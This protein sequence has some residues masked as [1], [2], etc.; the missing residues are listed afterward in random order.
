[1]AVDEY[2]TQ[3][4]SPFIKAGGAPEG[5]GAR[6]TPSADQPKVADVARELDRAHPG[7]RAIE[8][9]GG[10][11]FE[12]GLALARGPPAIDH[13]VA[14]GVF[15]DKGRDEF[16]RVL[17]VGIEDDEGIANRVR[18]PAV[19]AISLPKFRVR[20]TIVSAGWVRRDPP[21]PAKCRRSCHH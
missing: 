15:L 20:F 12:P 4:K 2:P 17:E 9:A 11:G 1:M 18:N 14:L 6:R 7:H 3:A 19:S 8:Q 10:E 13:V 21:S 16:G 5:S